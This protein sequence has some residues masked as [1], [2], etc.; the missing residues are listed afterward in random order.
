ML[1][2]GGRPSR[3]V[4]PIREG[5]AHTPAVADPADLI[6][7]YDE[8]SA[9]DD[10]ATIAAMRHPEWRM[11]WPQSGEVVTSHEDYVGMRLNRPEGAPATAPL[12]RGGAGDLWWSETVIDYADGAR[13]LALAVIELRDGLV[14]HE[15]VYFGQPFK[16]PAWRARW[17]TQGPPVLEESAG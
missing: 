5:V 10:F 7:R 13:W 6:T 3:A 11:E 1:G 2:R 9:N 16:A 14:Y 17:V 12:R 15:R 4:R 8:A